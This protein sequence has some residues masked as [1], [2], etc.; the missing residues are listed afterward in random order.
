M[1]LAQLSDDQIQ[2]YYKRY[3]ALMSVNKRLEGI[4]RHGL[5]VKFAYHLCRL[6]DE[7]QQILETGTLNLQK[8]QDQLKSI[9]NGDWTL[10]EIE[11]Y[12]KRREAQLELLYQNSTLQDRPDEEKIKVLLLECLEIGYGSIDKMLKI[13]ESPAVEKLKKIQQILDE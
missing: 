1:K 13:D 6:I 9:R 11:D 4:K 3:K 12:F 10:E 5:D 8:N 7:A 2:E